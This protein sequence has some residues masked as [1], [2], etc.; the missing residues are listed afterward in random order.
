[1]TTPIYE[2]AS[3]LDIV[4]FGY[5]KLFRTLGP[6]TKLSLPV[7]LLSGVLMGSAY[8]ILLKMQHYAMAA[9][10]SF[11]DMATLLG[12]G[13]AVLFGVM[14]MFY[15][16]YVLLRYARDL[17]LDEVQKNIYAYLKPEQKFVGM[18]GIAFLLA[19]ATIPIGLI[20]F[21]GFLFLVVPGLIVVLA[22]IFAGVRLVLVWNIYMIKASDIFDAFVRSWQLTRGNFWRTLGL[23]FLVA[24]IQNI[25]GLP[26]S[27][28]SSA[29][30]A[31]ASLNPSFTNTVLFQLI[32]TIIFSIGYWAQYVIGLG[33]SIFVYYRYYFDLEARH[34]LPP[35]SGEPS[36]SQPFTHSPWQQ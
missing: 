2:P 29:N 30:D 34:A 6:L 22:L 17:Y 12:V 20:L 14:L 28:L 19:I 1:M 18:I 31:I 27:V 11:D 4:S 33:G 24:I 9:P 3:V 5:R 25:I 26:F 10:Q 36:S 15:F 13:V 35:G 8:P 7:A 23:V 21:L 16:F 32:C